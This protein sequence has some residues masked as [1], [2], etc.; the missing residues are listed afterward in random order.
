MRDWIT[1]T[2]K[3]EVEILLQCHR[4]GGKATI[5]GATYTSDTLAMAETF[6]NQHGKCKEAQ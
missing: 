1:A 3:G 5:K 6:A 2:A 4:C